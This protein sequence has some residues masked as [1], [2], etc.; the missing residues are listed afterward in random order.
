ML[1]EKPALTP[2]DDRRLLKALL[3]WFGGK[4]NGLNKSEKTLD[5]CF[6]AG[7]PSVLFSGTST[8]KGLNYENFSHLMHMIPRFTLLYNTVPVHL[9]LPA[10]SDLFPDILK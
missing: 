9:L 6:I 5:A 8:H 2:F 7:A 1:I 4:R 10:Q 3:R